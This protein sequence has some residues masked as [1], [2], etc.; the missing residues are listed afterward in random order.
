MQLDGMADCQVRRI[1]GRPDLQKA[2]EE[3]SNRYLFVGITERFAESMI[4][5][6]R[7]WTYP[8]KLE[9]ERLHVTKDNTA[10]QDVLNNLDSHRLLKE[11]NA[12]DSQ[13][14]RYVRDE[15][16]PSLRKRAG[17]EAQEL[18]EEDFPPMQYPLRYKLTR[19]YNQSVYR[20]LS[21][22]RR[23]FRPR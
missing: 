19:A 12:L 14:Y 16:Y 6:Q 18:V 17:L 10:K 13:L 22:V 7:L 15:L 4:V 23:W 2:I 5:L 1:A 20:S 3:L 9:Y 8:L 11:S 21:K